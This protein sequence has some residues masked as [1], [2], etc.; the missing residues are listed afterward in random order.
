[1]LNL[2]TFSIIACDPASGMFGVAASTKVPAVG[3]LVPYTRA[4]V[5]AI[6][7]QARTNPLLGFDGLDLLAAGYGAEEA[8][9][10]LLGADHEAEKRQISIVDSWGTRRSTRAPGRTPGADTSPGKATR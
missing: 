10:E 6:A 3:A 8:L 1:M 9:C 7:T 5:G 4:G 2:N